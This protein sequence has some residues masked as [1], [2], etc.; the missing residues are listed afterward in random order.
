M[1]AHNA[2][3]RTKCEETPYLHGFAE[4]AHDENVGAFPSKITNTN[5][6]K[7]TLDDIRK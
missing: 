1:H 2:S 7:P 5:E 6:L 3:F 4:K